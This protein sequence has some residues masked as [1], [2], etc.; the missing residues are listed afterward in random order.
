MRCSSRHLG[1]C[2]IKLCF[3]AF[4]G[5]NKLLEGTESIFMLFL[6][7]APV[8][9]DHHSL[10]LRHRHRQR[11]SFAGGIITTVTTTWRSQIMVTRTS[12]FQKNKVPRSMCKSIRREVEGVKAK[13][14]DHSELKQ[15]EDQI[16]E[17]T[18]GDT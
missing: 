12:Y 8:T 6:M 17:Q 13:Y 7:A 14:T 4:H 2:Q 3:T 18:S 9:R 15:R 1:M 10:V 5:I 16:K 11:I